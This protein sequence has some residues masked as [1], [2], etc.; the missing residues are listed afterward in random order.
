M[1]RLTCSHHKFYFTERKTSKRIR[2]VREETD[3]DPN[4]YQTRSCV[5]RRL[6]EK[7]AKPLR[8][9][10][11]RNGQKRNR[12]STMLEDREEFVL[13]IQTTENTQKFSKNA[14]RKLERSVAATMPCKRKAPTWTTK[15]V[16]EQELA[17]QQIHQNEFWLTSGIS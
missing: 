9:E 17:S 3:K 6:D 2:V 4:N 14:R 1:V 12:S 15:V 13:M 5:A 16:A 8:I 7:S 11:N 10:K